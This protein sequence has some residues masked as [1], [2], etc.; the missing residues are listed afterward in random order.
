[1]KPHG[2]TILS[3]LGLVLVVVVVVTLIRAPRGF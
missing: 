1:M 3:S 2:Q